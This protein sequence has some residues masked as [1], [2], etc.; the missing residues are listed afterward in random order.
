MMQVK[1]LDQVLIVESELEYVRNLFLESILPK[2]FIPNYSASSE[3]TYNTLPTFIILN[4]TDTKPPLFRIGDKKNTY[5]LSDN[6]SGKVPTYILSLIQLIFQNMHANKSVVTIHSSAAQGETANFVFVG[7]AGVG[8]TS[9]LLELMTRYDFKYISN[10]KTLLFY[11]KSSNKARIIGGTEAVSIRSTTA[12]PSYEYLSDKSLITPYGRLAFTIN[13]KYQAN[14]NKNKPV[15]II[16]PQ[17]NP[18]VE[19]FSK[20][21]LDESRIRLYPYFLDAIDREVALF[22]YKTSLSS[23]I[24]LS[25]HLRKLLLDEMNFFLSNTPVYHVSG[26]IEFICERIVNLDYNK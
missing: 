23:R 15:Y 16:L 19:E 26:S 10:N 24:I 7:H 17:I 5:I 25:T 18:G 20:I 3:I 2:V 9:I 22:G 8:K 13:K 11:D 6:L 12:F 1:S 14:L 4:N 21:N